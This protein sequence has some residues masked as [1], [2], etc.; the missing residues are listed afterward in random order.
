MMFYNLNTCVL[1]FFIFIFLITPFLP[2]GNL[3]SVSHAQVATAITSDIKLEKPTRVIPGADGKTYNIL[4]GTLKGSNLFHSFD[5]FSVGEGDIARFHDTR[6]G[7]ANILSR[8]TGGDKSKIFGTLSSTIQGANLYLFNPAGV[9]FG[10][11]A[12]LDVKGSFHLSTADYLRLDDGKR[13]NAI[14][15]PQDKLLTSAPVTAFGFL[16]GNPEAITVQGSFLEVPNGETISMIG[17]KMEIKPG[18]A[19]DGELKN[20]YLYAPEGQ[21]SVVSVCIC[22]GGRCWGWCSRC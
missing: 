1:Q 14:P 20:G 6:S 13:F 17:G 15:G 8:V 4:D 19:G 12:K 16:S 21:I 7:I 3:N 5:Q 10:P 9:A 11:D 18:V 2:L 22:W